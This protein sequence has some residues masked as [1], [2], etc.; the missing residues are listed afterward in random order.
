MTNKNIQPLEHIDKFEILDA[1]YIED[2]QL[3]NIQNYIKDF[4]S[5][6]NIVIRDLGLS[7]LCY[8]SNDISLTHNDLVI[9]IRRED[10]EYLSAQEINIGHFISGIVDKIIKSNDCYFAW[11]DIGSEVKESIVSGSDENGIGCNG[12]YSIYIRFYADRNK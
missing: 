11:I 9:D 3:I 5:Q 10:G 6:C 4:I 12:T 1:L 2:E 8:I 7:I